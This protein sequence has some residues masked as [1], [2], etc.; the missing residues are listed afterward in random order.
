[1]CR[2]ATNTND[3]IDGLINDLYPRVVAQLDAA[4]PIVKQLPAHKPYLTLADAFFNLRQE[5]LSLAAYEDRL[6]FP[7]V[8]KVF[9]QK[10][11]QPPTRHP[12]IAELQA[13]TKIKEQKLQLLTLQLADQLQGI[14]HAQAHRALQRICGIM[15]SEFAEAKQAWNSMI[16]DRR[17][18]C[19]CFMRF[20]FPDPQNAL[21]Y[22][23]T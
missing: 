7:S 21:P 1:M 20:Q 18:T 10:K 23:S 16:D 19:A 5:F 17:S 13:L 6:V 9:S 4:L 14:K 2:H 15:L 12:N 22:V 3:S 11:G 8:M